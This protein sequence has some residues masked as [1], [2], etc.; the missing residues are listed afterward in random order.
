MLQQPPSYL[1]A[2]DPQCCEK[3]WGVYIKH[4]VVHT[5]GG[6]TGLRIITYSPMYVRLFSGMGGCERVDVA[7]HQ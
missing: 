3:R 7:E 2:L 5:E 1:C 4:P 6:I